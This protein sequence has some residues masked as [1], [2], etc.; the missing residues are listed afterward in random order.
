MPRNG[1]RAS[2]GRTEFILGRPGKVFEERG[3]SGRKRR[4]AKPLYSVKLYRG[5]D[6]SAQPIRTHKVRPKGEGQ[7]WPESIPLSVRLGKVIQ[8]KFLRRDG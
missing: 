7:K 8:E 6:K 1:C 3:L 4:F 5:F 2:A